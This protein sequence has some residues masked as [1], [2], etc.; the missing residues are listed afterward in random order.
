MSMLGDTMRLNQ[1]S[2]AARSVAKPDAA[3]QIVE[4]IEVVATA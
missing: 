3:V 2:A 1:M 4:E